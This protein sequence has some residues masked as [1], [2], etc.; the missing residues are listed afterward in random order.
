[1]SSDKKAHTDKARR[2]QILESL[3]ASFKIEGIDIPKQFA[4]TALKNLEL[5]LG[6]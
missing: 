6:K 1:M 5:T 2:K 4:A 3:L